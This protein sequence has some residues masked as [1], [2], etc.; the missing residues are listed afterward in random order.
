MDGFAGAILPGMF[1]DISALSEYRAFAVGN[2]FLFNTPGQ[3][4]QD[5]A[6]L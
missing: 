1:C 6:L 2:I 5:A 3:E 4:G